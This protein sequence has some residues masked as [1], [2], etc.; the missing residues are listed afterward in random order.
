[1]SA[2]VLSWD[3]IAA[4]VNIGY[5]LD[6]RGVTVHNGYQ[7]LALHDE[8]DRSYVAAELMAQNRTSGAHR[9]REQVIPVTDVPSFRLPPTRIHDLAGYA[10]ALQWINCYCYQ[11]CEDPGWS[12]TFACHYTERLRS[13]LEGKIIAAFATSWDYDGPRLVHTA[14]N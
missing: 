2:Y 14:A 5:Q 8:H 10:Q 6:L 12:T 1:M 7:T 11:S 3:H 9:Y 4:L 13:E